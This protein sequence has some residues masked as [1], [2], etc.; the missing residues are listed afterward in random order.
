[1]GD[2]FK[3]YGS[4]VKLPQAGGQW[5]FSVRPGGWVMAERQ[6]PRGA[7]ERRRVFMAEAKGKLSLSLMGRLWHG[8]VA[9]TRQGAGGGSAGSDSD[10]IAQF[11]GKVRKILCQEG[12]AVQ[13]GEPLL[14]VEA[15]KME[16][17]VKAPA[18]G[19]VTR[20]LVKEAQQLQ[21]GDRFVD[22]E[23]AESGG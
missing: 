19:K 6:L 9:S 10:L 14:L 23:G 17:A 2:L 15:M 4:K 22:F 20:I 11:P 7:V 21:P 16:F 5:K 18:A 8:E 12:Q 3:V 1:M 13:E